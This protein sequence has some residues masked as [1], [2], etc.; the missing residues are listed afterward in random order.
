MSRSARKSFIIAISVVVAIVLAVGVYA[1]PR[2][3]AAATYDAAEIV[4]Q[5]EGQKRAMETWYKD[6]P[7]GS[8]APGPVEKK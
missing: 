1:W 2:E 8:K 6:H 3:K 7:P 4:K 5:G